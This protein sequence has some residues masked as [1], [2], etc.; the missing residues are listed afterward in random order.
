MGY[1]DNLNVFVAICFDVGDEVMNEQ[2]TN[3]IDIEGIFTFNE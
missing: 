2:I 1:F 3:D